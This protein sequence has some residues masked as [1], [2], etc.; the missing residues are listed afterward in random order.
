MLSTFVSL[1]TL[2]SRTGADAR[3]QICNGGVTAFGARIVSSFGYSSL[4]TILILIPGGAFTMVRTSGSRVCFE[5]L[6]KCADACE[7]LIKVSIYLF[8]WLAGRLKNSTTYLIPISCIPVVVGS[9][10][11]WL[12]RTFNQRWG[13]LALT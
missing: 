11:I 8:G 7:P 1:A 4:T 3:A 9:L 2:K 10:V 5:T 13:I 6:L 12:A